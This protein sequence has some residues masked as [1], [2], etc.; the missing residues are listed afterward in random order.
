MII[1]WLGHSC[2]KISSS[3]ESIVID[4]FEDNSVP[5]LKNIREEANLV[6][7]THNHH[8]HNGI[9]NVKIIGDNH[10]FSVESYLT[11]HDEENGEK[12][13]NTLWMILIIILKIL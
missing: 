10:V 4:P 6:L 12:W 5:G 7:S 11:F 3:N 9:S 1:K 13:K 8:D 2:F